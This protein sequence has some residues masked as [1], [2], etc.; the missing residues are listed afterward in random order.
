MKP[1]IRQ[2]LVEQR[3][4]NAMDRWLLAVQKLYCSGPER[5]RYAPA[6]EPSTDPCKA[7]AKS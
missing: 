7:V 2:Q 3:R 1:E 4:N 6:F 5:V